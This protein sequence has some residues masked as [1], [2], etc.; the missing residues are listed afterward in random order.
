MWRSPKPSLVFWLVCTLGGIVTFLMTDVALDMAQV[1]RCLVLL[2]YLGSINPSGWMASPTTALVFLGGLGLR[3]IS[4]S[5][6]AVRLSLV[7]VFRGLILGLP[8]GVL[9]VFF[10]LRAMAFWAPGIDVPNVEGRL[11]VS[12]CLYIT[13][14]LHQFLPAI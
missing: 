12:F 11:Q 1:L 7:F 13:Y 6:G 3:L 2:Y 10:R 8:V 14:L 5:G 4:G 9:L